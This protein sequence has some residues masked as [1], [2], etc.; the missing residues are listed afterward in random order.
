MTQE[1]LKGHLSRQK[2]CRSEEKQRKALVERITQND[3]QLQASSGDLSLDFVA[4]LSEA[5]TLMQVKPQGSNS[6]NHLFDP[7][8]LFL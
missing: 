7:R 1:Q 3:V 8:L 2:R 6:E 4:P 5:P